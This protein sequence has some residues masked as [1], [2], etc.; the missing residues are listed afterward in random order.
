MTK[1]TKRNET[2]QS[3]RVRRL[4]V[5]GLYV[6][7]PLWAALTRSSLYG[8]A[9]PEGFGWYA[10][11]EPWLA[12]GFF[13]IFAVC[14]VKLM[15]SSV[16][17]IFGEPRDERQQAAFARAY[18]LSYRILAGLV[19]IPGILFSVPRIFVADWFNLTSSSWAG[20]VSNLI[21][22]VLTL[23]KAVAM[24]L[25]PDPPTEENFSHTSKEIA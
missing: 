19:V 24:W 13:V 1:R 21:L 12:F 10:D 5:V 9:P 3:R 22:V 23:P 20:I 8:G 18:S 11:V 17:G 2:L 15:R 4:T 16:G 7:W 14:L 25:E 6:S